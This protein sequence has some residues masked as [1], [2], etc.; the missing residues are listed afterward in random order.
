MKIKTKER[1]IDVRV[2]ILPTVHG[3]KCVLRLLGSGEKSMT[4]TDLGF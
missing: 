1:D 3:E 2:S 4:L